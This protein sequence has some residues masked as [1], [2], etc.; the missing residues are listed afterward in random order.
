MS[1]PS[2]RP[3]A[4]TLAVGALAVLLAVAGCVMIVRGLPQRTPTEQWLLDLSSWPLT[5]AVVLMV[6]RV[7]AERR[8]LAARPL[9]RCFVVGAVLA[10]LGV[11]AWL[12]VLTGVAAPVL[13]PTG[14]QLLVW[15]GVGAWVLW[16]VRDG[17]RRQRTTVWSLA[18]RDRD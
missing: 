2:R 18:D 7:A 1:S 14:A 11:V 5:L 17:A 15:L 3:D 4:A 6:A 10:G 13:T 16:I 9:P 8:L 12:L